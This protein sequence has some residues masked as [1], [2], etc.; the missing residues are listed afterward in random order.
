MALKEWKEGKG[1]ILA[2]SGEMLIAIDVKTV[3]I[4]TPPK[5]CRACQEQE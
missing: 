4:K 1:E 3:L 5:N 2:L